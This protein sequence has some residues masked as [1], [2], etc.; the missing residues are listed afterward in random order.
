[1]YTVKIGSFNCIFP[2]CDLLVV[3]S[4]ISIR[5][6]NRLAP[7]QAPYLARSSSFP[8]DAAYRLSPATSVISRLPPSG[9]P[10]SISSTCSTWAIAAS[11]A[12][13]KGSE[14]RQTVRKGGSWDKVRLAAPASGR[15]T[16][17]VTGRAADR[18]ATILQGTNTI[19][20]PPSPKSSLSRS[21]P[22][23]DSPPALLSGYNLGSSALASPDSDT[24]HGTHLFSLLTTHN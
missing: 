11:R 20:A 19:S 18:A 15:L 17:I 13:L 21:W 8:T 12:E 4:Q 2:K 24:Q 10:S 6:N 1:M 16:T 3:P 14:R 9:P 5:E 7:R 22:P 23:P